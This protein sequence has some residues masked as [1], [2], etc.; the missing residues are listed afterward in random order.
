MVQTRHCERVCPGIYLFHSQ[1][2]SIR[3]QRF[4]IHLST[5]LCIS[6]MM[7]VV[8]VLS[9][10]Y[11]FIHSQFHF[12]HNKECKIVHRHKHAHAHDHFEIHATTNHEADSNTHTFFLCL[13]RK[14]RHTHNSKLKKNKA[15]ETRGE[16]Y[17]VA[18]TH[19]D[20]QT[21][22]YTNGISNE[23][24]TFKCFFFLNSQLYVHLCCGFFWIL[25]KINTLLH[26]IINLYDTAIWKPSYM[27]NFDSIYTWTAVHL[28]AETGHNSHRKSE[29]E[30]SAMKSRNRLKR[31]WI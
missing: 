30:Y 2:Y 6:T 20:T 7:I 31:E 10:T 3:Y 16:K 24:F 5:C 1:I 26:Y 17:S 12:R 29:S 25:I 23:A 14:H 9:C 8:F 18:H 4:K 27:D 28:N 11:S 15:N 13:S 21:H 19:S 22:W